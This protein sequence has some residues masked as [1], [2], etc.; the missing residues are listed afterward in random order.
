LI[1]VAVKPGDV[2]EQPP[3]QLAKALGIDPSS[4]ETLSA[5]E[6]GAILKH[7]LDAPLKIDLGSLDDS[8]S[9]ADEITFGQLLLAEKPDGDVLQRVQRFAKACKSHPAG[10]LPQEVAAVL[11]FAAITK[12]VLALGQRRSSLSDADLL[13]GV[14]WSL[15]RPWLTGEIRQLLEKGEQHLN[16]SA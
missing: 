8:P 7:Q 3:S 15:G 2:D 12:S 4:A 5:T 9:P 16:P 14:R 11:Y 13:S 6:L 10:V 1:E